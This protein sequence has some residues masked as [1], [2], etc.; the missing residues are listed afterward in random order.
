MFVLAV[1]MAVKEA[2]EAMENRNAGK[3]YFLSGRPC[4]GA[5]FILPIPSEMRPVI[6]RLASSG[7]IVR[8]GAR[9]LVLC[10]VTKP[11]R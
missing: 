11:S 8:Q 4:G 7:S 6:R 9:P 1:N 5:D 10:P 3:G 2:R